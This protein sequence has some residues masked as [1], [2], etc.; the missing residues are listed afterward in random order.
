MD[1]PSLATTRGASRP[2]LPPDALDGG[3]SCLGFDLREMVARSDHAVVFDARAPGS[4]RPLT[5][6]VL[7]RWDALPPSRRA[8]VR[9]QMGA[10]AS[11]QVRGAPRELALHVEGSRAAVV[12]DRVVGRPIGVALADPATHGVLAARWLAQAAALLG[13]VHAVAK[14]SF[15][16]GPG[17]VVAAGATVLGRLVPVPRVA[18]RQADLGA[19]HTW[20]LDAAARLPPGRFRADLAALA[21]SPPRTFVA[22]ADAL[23]A[24]EFGLGHSDPPTPGLAGD[25]ELLDRQGRHHAIVLRFEAAVAAGESP[26]ADAQFRY[27]TALQRCRRDA[28][29]AA[30]FEV[31]RLRFGGDSALLDARLLLAEGNLLRG[32]ETASLALADRVIA[33]LDGVPGGE[34]PLAQAY[35]RRGTLRAR[36]GDRAGYDDVARA[37]ELNLVHG[38]VRGRAAGAGQRGTQLRRTGDL[39]EALA[40]AT[41]AAR[42]AEPI[43]AHVARADA[44]Y[45]AADLLCGLGRFDEA[46]R[47]SGQSL[48]IHRE[49]GMHNG[50]KYWTHVRTCLWTGRLDEAWETAVSGATNA[51]RPVFR[52]ALALFQVVVRLEQGRIE[53]A[54]QLFDQATPVSPHRSELVA[55]QEVLRLE[56]LDADDASWFEE[57]ALLRQTLAH[58]KSEEADIIQSLV[59]HARRRRADPRRAVAL[60]D[61]AA[62]QNSRTHRPS[63]TAVIQAEVD[64]LRGTPAPI[65]RWLLTAPIGAGGMGQVWRAVDPATGAEAAVKV[66]SEWSTPAARDRFR[67]EVETIARLDHPGIVRLLE[68]EIVG[69]VAASLADVEEGAFALIMELADGG[70]LTRSQGSATAE[71]LRAVAASVLT[72]L[73]HAH[74]RDVVHLDLKPSN[75]LRDSRRGVLLAD[76][77]IAQVLAETGSRPLGG[78]PGYR[79]PEQRDPARLGPWSDLYALGCTLVALSAGAPPADGGEVRTGDASLDAWIRCLLAPSPAARF[80]SAIAALAALQGTERRLPPAPPSPEAVPPPSVLVLSMRPP[81]IVGRR[82]AQEWLWSALRSARDGARHVVLS[83]EEGMGVSRL[84]EWLVQTAHEVAGVRTLEEVEGPGEELSIALAPDDPAALLETWPGAPLLVISTARSGGDLHL[85]PLAESALRELGERGLGLSSETAAELAMRAEGRPG[86]LVEMTREEAAAGRL[87]ATARGL[88]RARNAEP[89]P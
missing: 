21:V 57:L 85:G 6:T 82:A 80:P 53:D 62:A 28:D 30:F 42:L 75:L 3:D 50:A 52:E 73:A 26:D 37:S 56:L 4:D 39:H 58:T 83:G 14:L 13:R 47:A 2:S 72:A 61:L 5:L 18:G 77:G 32:D 81:P 35:W 1:R 20:V 46:H 9:W 12:H 27:L 24:V 76:F 44:L 29:A 87:H 66:L 11:A 43:D 45:L 51:R 78:T 41:A 22:W 74:A 63:D 89:A 40:A 86:C 8:D 31:M 15:E 55:L 71:E 59:R 48:R 67:G 36:L 69:A 25:L 60:L 38:R 65:G 16:V 54:R 7:R 17:L 84:V 88:V 33:L 34:G 70:P 64:A 23:R 10:L 79:A 49:T 68:T 19:L